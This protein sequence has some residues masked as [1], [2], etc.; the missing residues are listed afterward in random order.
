[1]LLTLQAAFTL[2]QIT[3]SGAV[4]DTFNN[5]EPLIQPYNALNCPIDIPLSCSNKTQVENSCCFEYPSGI[6]LQAQFWDARPSV[7]PK[8]MFTMHGVWP[9]RCDGSYDQFC[10]LFSPIKSARAILEQFGENQLLDEMDRV[11][12]NI[13]GNDDYL[14]VHEFNK[15]GTC[16]NT[17]KPSCYDQE[18]YRE[19][20]NVVDFYKR[21]MQLFK[22]L[23]TYQWL[24]Q[25]GIV[26]SNSKLYTREEIESSLEEHFGH[27]VFVSCRGNMLQEVWYFYKL[28]GSIVA[29]DFVPID[30]VRASRC[31]SKG[32]RYLPK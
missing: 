30:T 21:S 3:I 12:K 15:H 5:Q 19:N 7:G 28:H 4:I 8:D 11:W 1:M 13:R 14:W 18:N 29:G 16:M 31:P 22:T 20:Q 24:A 6:F 32:V 26:P 17:L 10:K 25:S 9:D 23:P 27:P 2:F